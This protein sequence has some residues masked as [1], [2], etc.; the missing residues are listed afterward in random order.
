M[1][2]VEFIAPL[3]NA[4]QA[5]KC[6]CA[7]YYLK[8]NLNIEIATVPQVRNLLLRARVVKR[9]SRINHTRALASLNEKVDSPVKNM[10]QIT[11][12]GEKE[13]RDLLKLSAEE[14]ETE[15]DTTVLE[16]LIKKKISNSEIQDYLN[17]AVDC[18][19][20]GRL[21]ACVV[22][23]WAGSVYLIRQILISKN[24][25]KLN[26]YLKKHYPN[27]R[28]VKRIEDFAYIKDSILLLV[29]QD[30]GLCDKGQ[31]ETLE[32]CLSLRNKCGHPGKYSPGPKRVSAFIEDL[33]SVVFS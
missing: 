10:W 16:A 8:H 33:I 3:K 20:I 30:F 12:S 18:L 15:N 26:F 7:L 4:T 29:M 27:S 17:E 14:I 25:K 1:L 24:I 28:N 31:R 2:F 32:E 21:R 22:F 9:S 23:L 13:M 5:K 19:R 6:L 11:P